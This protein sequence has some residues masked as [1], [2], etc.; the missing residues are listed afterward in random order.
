MVGTGQYSPSSDEPASSYGLISAIGGVQRRSS[1]WVVFICARKHASR[2][3]TPS[4]P[5]TWR[6]PTDCCS[7]GHRC[8]HRA[9]GSA[10]GRHPQQ[11]AAFRF[12]MKRSGSPLLILRLGEPD[13]ALHYWKTATSRLPSNRRWACYVPHHFG[14]AGAPLIFERVKDYWGKDLAVNRSKIQFDPDASSTVTATSP[15]KAF[16]PASSTSTSSIR[17]RTGPTATTSRPCAVAQVIKAQ[18]AHQIRQSQEPVRERGDDL[19]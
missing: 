15:S 9:A 16:R 5:T 2:R 6:S 10:A 14:D 8:A 18:I 12:M 11:N 3:N 4:P 7:E 17:R 19:R 13:A 1:S